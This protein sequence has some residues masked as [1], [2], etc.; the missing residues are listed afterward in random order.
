[1]STATQARTS[2]ARATMGGVWLVAALELRLR[3]RSGKWIAALIAFG[4]LVGIFTLLLAFA[5]N[6]QMFGGDDYGVIFGTV[7]FFVLFMGLLVSPTLTATSINGDRKDGTLAPLQATTLSATTIVLGKL[8]AAWLASLAFLT[9]ALPF[10]VIG[11]VVSHAPF[12][13]AVVTVLVL[14]F[15][16]LVICA[17]GMGL[18][19]SLA[20]TA[21]SAVLTYLAVATLAVL[22]LVFFGLG[23]ALS[24]QPTTTR[25]Y[26]VSYDYDW[27]KGEPSI[28]AC[29]WREET[30]DEPH[31]EY[32]WWL[33][34]ANPF[35]IVADAAPAEDDFD[36]NFYD[37][38]TML[39]S[40][41]YAVREARLGPAEFQ[42]WCYYNYGD[43]EALPEELQRAEELQEL[44]AVWPWG[45]G[46]HTLLAAGSV[47]IAIRR[48]KVPY[49]KL[50]SG[51]RVA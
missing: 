39:G 43:T 45:I 37:D 35:V 16:L 29:E 49:G 50:I 21:A 51:T 28:E 11:A 15:E 4:S 44:S 3:V 41:K 40:I 31:T 6:G 26:D 9:V 48:V 30:W 38:Q 36:R 46:F 25:I 20:G 12:W 42:N 14:A 33:L 18:S 23:T 10:I 19:A 47:L 5:V 22:T 7:V 34:A 32:V 24:I 1:M 17:I 8:L 27:N 13:T 2:R